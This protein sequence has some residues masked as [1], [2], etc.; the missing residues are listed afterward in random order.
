MP[1]RAVWVGLV[2]VLVM[3]LAS[4]LS[5]GGAEGAAPTGGQPVVS[6]LPWNVAGPAGSSLQGLSC[7]APDS[8]LAVG[9]VSSQVTAPVAA[10]LSA[11]TWTTVPLPLPA[12]A[13]W[14]QMLDVDC[15]GPDACAGVGAAYTAQGNLQGSFVD[16]LSDGSWT[17]TVPPVPVGGHDLTLR[18]VACPSAGSCV[19]VGSYIAPSGIGR[20]IIETLA[21]GSWTASVPPADPDTDVTLSGVD[22]PAAGRCVAVGGTYTGD[23]VIEILANGVWTATVPSEPDG[24]VQ[25]RLSSISC[26]DTADCVAVGQ[27]RD[28]ADTAAPMAATLGDGSWTS[29]ALPTPTG[30]V[31]ASSDLSVSCFAPAACVAVGD[32]SSGAFVSTLAAGSWTSAALPSVPSGDQSR[33]NDVACT[34]VEACL[35]VGNERFVPRSEA[36]SETLDGTGWSAARVD[37]TGPPDA[38]LQAVACA[39]ASACVAAG[40]Y[41]DDQSQAGIL[42]E[43]LHGGTWTPTIPAPPDT[44][45]EPV[46]IACPSLAWCL[47]VV[48]TD[49]GVFADEYADGTWTATKL[50]LDI[51]AVDSVSPPSCPAVGRCMIAASYTT[52]GNVSSYVAANLAADT[53]TTTPLSRPAGAWNQVFDLT[54]SCPS[55]D[56]CASTGTFNDDNGG[57]MLAQ[58]L[59]H[60]VWSVARIT[61]PSGAAAPSL[62]GLSCPTAG[63]CVAV[64]RDA[65]DVSQVWQPIV[66]TL[67]AGAWHGIRLPLPADS[68]NASLAAVSCVSATACMAVGTHTNQARSTQ[69]PL[70]ERLVGATWT[71]T[72]PANP[73]GVHDATLAAVSCIAAASCWAVGTGIGTD[74]G[75]HPIAVQQATPVYVPPPHASALTVGTSTRLNYGSRITVATRLTDRT[76]HAAIAHTAVTLWWRATTTATWSRLASPTTSST[77]SASVTVTPTTSHQF[78]WRYTGATGHAAT[79]SAIQTATVVQTVAAY[80]TR[81]TI[82]RR[83]TVKIYGTVQPSGTGQRIYLQRKS[84]KR[85]VTVASTVLKRRTLPSHHATVGFV[86]TRKQTKKASLYFRVVKTATRSLAAGYSRTLHL[87]VR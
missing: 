87:R 76:T 70:L 39:D 12:S 82:Q 40:D 63:A 20:P 42:A 49:H 72:V 73:A 43:Q 78:Q 8:C 84:G 21:A 50:P 52:P 55:V 56:W 9:S 22:C 86:F 28:T 58:T 48:K 35:A 53:W 37:V 26:P 80:L 19:A 36:I 79:S 65:N 23:A 71:A 54:L 64:G 66:A 81:R 68:W 27:S 69:Q 46:G 15:A 30:G 57:G 6:A 13:A 41:T 47:A 14:G 3:T 45:P 31:D 10:V 7:W 60:G 59:N 32:T 61:A 18:G 2:A 34:A 1:Q 17:E 62:S 75:T 16:V 4:V 5:S 77:G 25:A 83:H 11:G 29:T 67:S 85:W 38:G 51:Q 24:T 33:V 74:G 44:D